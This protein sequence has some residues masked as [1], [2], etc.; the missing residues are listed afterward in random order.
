MYFAFKSQPSD[1]IVSEILPYELSG[2]GD[3]FYIFFE[4]EKL[5]TMEI[6]LRICETMKLKREQLGIAGLKDKEGITRQR[7]TISQKTLK[8]CWGKDQFLTF[9]KGKLRILRTWW[10][11]E[12]LAVGKNKGNHFEIRLRKREALPDKLKLELEA[13]LK[14]SRESWFPNAFW[15]QRFGKGNKNFK[16]TTKLFSGEEAI[17][18]GYEVKFKLQAFG[19]MWFNA[20]VM[21]RREEQAFLLDGDIMVNNWNA[22]GTW[23]AEYREGKLQHFD[24]WKIKEGFEEKSYSQSGVCSV[25]TREGCFLEPQHFLRSSDY[26]PE[27]RF[28]SGPVLGMEQLLARAGSEAR[29]F[30]D[31]L[32]AQ[33]EFNEKGIQ[34]SERYKLYGFRRPLWI[35]AQHLE[36]SWEDNDLIL[37]FSLP[38]GA[39]ASIFLAYV[40][41]G[42]DPKGCEANNLLIPNHYNKKK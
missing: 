13:K 31:W 9:L 24:Y 27:L 8:N 25:E 42:I 7:L 18:G 38:T 32:I 19:S 2:N 30:D 20:Y 21:K 37:N 40:L 36:W 23:I 34:I 39:Y 28:P 11:D 3:F 41:E 1:F 6:V 10:H 14:Q 33:S 15:I 17:K 29:K 5:N 35:K 12:P 4:K 26:N 16:K 22:F